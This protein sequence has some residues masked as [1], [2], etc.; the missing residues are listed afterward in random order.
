MKRRISFTKLYLMVLILGL[1]IYGFI[2]SKRIN[3]LRQNIDDSK[4]QVSEEFYPISDA[5]LDF[6]V[7]DGEI[8]AIK[9]DLSLLQQM[10]L[11]NLD[12]IDMLEEGLEI[13]SET[14]TIT[15]TPQ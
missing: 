14:E 13:K 15:I 8:K 6:E 7:I 11:D 5:L 9:I 10:T 4:I 2:D 1:L 3:E 12:R